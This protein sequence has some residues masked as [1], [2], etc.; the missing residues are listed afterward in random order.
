M[1]DGTLDGIVL[2][3]VEGNLVG[4]LLGILVG[5]CVGVFVGLCC[6]P[7]VICTKATINMKN[8]LIIRILSHNLTTE[9]VLD[10]MDD[11]NS[12]NLTTYFTDFLLPTSNSTKTRS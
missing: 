9:I 4:V 6:S 3:E 2:G 10:M 5:I 12:A 7:P 11:N 1:L 8:S